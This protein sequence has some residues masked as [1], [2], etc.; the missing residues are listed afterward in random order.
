VPILLHPP[1][2]TSLE[3][4]LLDGTKLRFKTVAAPP[5]ADGRVFRFEE[6]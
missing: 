1:P 3:L 4:E 6:G 5:P 2:G